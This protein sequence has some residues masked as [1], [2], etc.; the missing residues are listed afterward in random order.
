MTA[1]TSRPA[2]IS[3]SVKSLKHVYTYVRKKEAPTS[4]FGVVCH[5]NTTFIVV[6]LHC[7]LP[8][9]P[10]T[11][12]TNKQCIN[13]YYVIYIQLETSTMSIFQMRA[14]FVWWNLV[15]SVQK[16]LRHMTLL[17]GIWLHCFPWWLFWTTYYFIEHKIP[18][19]MAA[20][21]LV[22]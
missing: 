13:I 22:T 11:V 1:K 2:T 7:Y 19:Q 17:A 10:G 3:L 20:I 16:K 15:C 6:C 12:P 5:S 21:C 4:N 14:V 18:L 9:T 8:S